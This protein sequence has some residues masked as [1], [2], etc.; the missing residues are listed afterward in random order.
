MTERERDWIKEAQA[1]QLRVRNFIDGR[2]QPES[3]E[4]AIEKFSPRDGQL[5]CRF[6]A[7]HPEEVELAVASAKRAAADGRWS[8]TPVQRRK[9]ILYRLA[10]LVNEHQDE[11]A[12]LESLDVGKPISDARAIDVPSTAAYLRFAAEAADKAY[13]KV[14]AVDSSNL[15]FELR[16]PM[17]VV[18]GIIGWNFPLLLAALKVGPVLATGNCL[19]LK[20]S[21]LTS[22][23]AAR[24]AELALEAGVPQGVFNVVHGGGH[25]GAALARHQDVDLLTFTGS[26]RTGKELLVASGQS[27]MKRLVLECG[28]KSPNIVFEDCPSLDAVADSVVGSAFW[29]QGQVCVA[30]SRLLVQESIKDELLQRVVSRTAEM[31]CGDPL[32]SRT[33]FGALVSRGHRDKVL[34]YIE[35]GKREGANVVH[36]CN[37]L[38]P[39][40][41]GFY[42]GPVIFDGVDPGQRIAREEIFGPVLSVISFRDET[43]AIRIAN[44]TIYGLSAVLWTRDLGRAHRVTHAVRAGWMIVNA[45]DKPTGGP[46]EGVLAIGGHKES[47]IGLEGGVEG[48]DA[49]TSKTAAQFFV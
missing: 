35:S 49:Y 32:E 7:G 3:Q 23:S 36:Q 4:R 22:F 28:G 16:R 19:V 9:E 12:L 5:L 6:G 42:V 21:E 13:G 20:P 14:Y 1:L 38:P 44:D 48:L 46:G 2:Y 33:R 27:N 34:A 40:G 31:T 17:G 30:S 43:E 24:L 26:T 25:V 39:F 15:S 47:G 41:N 18:A 37:A 10:T 45:T 11:L 8:Q 29:N